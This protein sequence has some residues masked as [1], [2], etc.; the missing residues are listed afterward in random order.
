MTLNE[1]RTTTWILA[2]LL[3][4]TLSSCASARRPEIPGP[5]ELSPP[6]DDIPANVEAA[7]RATATPPPGQDPADTSASS[8]KTDDGAKGRHDSNSED[9]S[10][11]VIVIE[12]AKSTRG[13]TLVEAARAARESR[14]KAGPSVASVTNDNLKDY[15]DAPLTF[16][17]PEPEAKAAAD[18]AAVKSGKGASGEKAGEKGEKYWRSRVLDLRLAL[19]G[20]VDGYGD[21]Q[22]KAAGLRRSFYAEDDPYVRDGQ[23]KPAWDRALDQIAAT[24][25]SIDDLQDQLTETL[26]EGRQ[27]GALPGWLREGIDLEPSADELP[28]PET[29]AKPGDLKTYEPEEPKVLDESSQQPPPAV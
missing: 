9:P 3:I 27:A 16:A 7:A 21:L 23:I 17:Q 2:G 6:H 28:P 8:A 13:Q 15:Q 20:A 24:R 22:T 26:E 18:E 29:K 14:G 19:R 4:T 1:A 12:R 11:K 5:G 25:K 10:S